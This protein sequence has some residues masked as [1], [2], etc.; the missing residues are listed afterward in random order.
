M[1][2]YYFIYHKTKPFYSIKMN[3]IIDES[4]EMKTQV[5]SVTKEVISK[6][7]TK[8][9]FS[10][11]KV[12]IKI[13]KRVNLQIDEDE[14]CKLALYEIADEIESLYPK[15]VESLLESTNTTLTKQCSSVYMAFRMNCSNNFKNKYSYHG[16]IN[17]AANHYHNMIV[18]KDERTIK[19]S[20]I[21]N[22]LLNN[23]DHYNEDELEWEQ[24]KNLLE[25]KMKKTLNYKKLLLATFEEF[26]THEKLLLE[27]IIQ[28]QAIRNGKKLRA[29]DPKN[30]YCNNFTFAILDMPYYEFS[31]EDF[32]LIMCRL[33]RFLTGLVITLSF[34]PDLNLYL[35]FFA[36]EKTI[37][38]LAEKYKYEMCLKNYAAYYIGIENKYRLEKGLAKID[39]DNSEESKLLVNGYLNPSLEKEI[40]QSYELDEEN[41]INYP[42]FVPF[43]LDK[44]TKFMRYV[45][46]DKTHA[47]PYDI[48]LTDKRYHHDDVD[49]VIEKET[50]K[51]SLNVKFSRHNSILDEHNQIVMVDYEEPECCSKFRNID[52]LRLIHQEVD[53][54]VSFKNM[55]QGGVYHSLTFCNNYEQYK[56]KLTLSNLCLENANYFNTQKQYKYIETIRNYYGEKIA[57]YFLF[58][59]KLLLWMIFPAV[60]GAAC[61]I[62]HSLYKEKK[63]VDIMFTELTVKDIVNLSFC[64]VITVWATLF[65]DSWRQDEKKFSYFWGT[66][67]L[68]EKEAKRETFV[69]DKE[70]RF[71]FNQNIEKE[72]KVRSV[73][74]TVVS[75]L[76]IIVMM[77]I[78]ISL[79]ILLFIFKN[80]KAISDP[81][82]IYWPI[83]IGALN[84][85][86]IKVMSFLYRIVTKKVTD[87]ENYSTETKYE[88]ALA[89][90]YIFF[91]FINCYSS[92]FYI[93]YF[94]RLIEGKCAEEDHC[95]KEMNL[96]IYMI[97]AT[98]LAINIVEI[99]LPYLMMMYRSYSY[100]EEC[101]LI[102][103]GKEISPV[104][105]S[106]EYQNL[107]EEYNTTMND[108]IEL[109]ISFGYVS[110]FSVVCPLTPFLVILLLFLERGVDTFKLVFLNRVTAIN[111]A[112]GIE[113]FSLIFKIIYFLGM[114]NSIGIIIF[115]ELNDVEYSV[116]VKI[117]IFAAVENLVLILMIGLRWNK[118]PDWFIH[119]GLVKQ[120]Y[121][122]MFYN[123]LSSRLPHHFLKQK[124]ISVFKENQDKTGIDII[125]DLSHFESDIENDLV[126]ID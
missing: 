120:L 15:G 64:G 96:Q 74:K 5:K 35:K 28:R 125:K 98:N 103:G 11:E 115:T 118:L 86:Q 54:F 116:A 67:E 46:N 111:T 40:L 13:Q 88:N 57:F 80:K 48:E 24:T 99:G 27:E 105:H 9:T 29:K 108:Y 23:Q 41:V 20:I 79:I 47:C 87:W 119:I 94:K 19:P 122:K 21:S 42:P 36:D 26:D 100:K 43:E 83:L 10:L 37:E 6:Y 109:V 61:F 107:C 53:S 16:R 33:I 110:L 65:L 126:K 3:D 123:K 63:G 52:R 30:Y 124:S 4:F 17:N 8:K 84:S 62:F 78:S 18:N 71:L 102:T 45:I 60:V 106:L 68:G 49:E 97:L 91:E 34:T 31:Y 58:I 121:N 93:A 75:I 55:T 89:L 81:D 7:I 25:R 32:I 104:L 92:L 82:S 112:D 22:L 114:T 72:D 50:I 66:T 56:D 59:Y 70:E 38:K 12:L 2:K 69:P 1:I 90:K 51:S 95:V 39:I 85:V 77:G 44:K 76:V 73:L 113:V 117:A 14:M 101:K